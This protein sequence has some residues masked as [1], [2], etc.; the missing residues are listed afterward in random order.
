MRTLTA[1]EAERVSSQARGDGNRPELFSSLTATASEISEEF[2]IFLILT[3]V[4]VRNQIANFFQVIL[5]NNPN[6]LEDRADLLSEF[7]EEELRNDT[8]SLRA[9]DNYTELYDQ[10]RDSFSNVAEGFTD[11][12]ETSLLQ[13]AINTSLGPLAELR[14]RYQFNYSVLNVLRS[15]AEASGNANFRSELQSWIRVL[16]TYE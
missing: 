10:I 6:D 15:R 11:V 16:A 4:S 12:G 14:D 8:E 3:P 7:L 1:E 2:E 9:F 5:E 13:E